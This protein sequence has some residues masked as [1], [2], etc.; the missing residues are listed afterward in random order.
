[1]GIKRR[2]LILAGIVLVVGIGISVYL[3]ARPSAQEASKAIPATPT[4]NKA[5]AEI[6]QLETTFNSPDMATQ[7]KALAP[8]L[9]EQ[10]LQQGQNP[11]AGI[12]VKF[13]DA[14][15]QPLGADAATIEATFSNGER[16]RVHFVRQT[17]HW[18]IW[19]TEKR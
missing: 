17:G 9:G 3:L 12:T 11:L 18:Y 7:S 5:P 14:S 2:L 4:Q 16:Y 19:N 13:D 10:Y 15:Y 1:M 6:K 8:G